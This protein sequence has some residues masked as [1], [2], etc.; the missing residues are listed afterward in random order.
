V[1]LTFLPYFITSASPIQSQAPQNP[2]HHGSSSPFPFS[3]LHCQ[4]HLH[5]NPLTTTTNPQLIHHHRTSFLLPLCLH[6]NRQ[7]TITSILTKPETS[8]LNHPNHDQHIINQFHSKPIHGR[9]HHHKP[10]HQSRCS[11]AYTLC[12]YSS[13]FSHHQTMPKA[14]SSPIAR[15]QSQFIINFTTTITEPRILCQFKLIITSS[16]P[17]L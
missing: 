2:F 6:T 8:S 10:K 5:Q 9:L 3:R 12:L 11:R 7:P 15:A 4:S 14:S 1:I 13:L 17:T 16:S